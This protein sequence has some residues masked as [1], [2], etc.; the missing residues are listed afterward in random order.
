M[1][2]LVTFLR[3][4]PSGSGILAPTHEEPGS[5]KKLLPARVSGPRPDVKHGAGEFPMNIAS[6]YAAICLAF[7][8]NTS[9]CRIEA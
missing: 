6:H 4:A 1:M 2:P 8:T 9:A 3:N 7:S 5:P